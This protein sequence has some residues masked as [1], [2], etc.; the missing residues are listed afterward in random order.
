MVCLFNNYLCSNQTSS[1][2]TSDQP[3]PLP[4]RRLTRVERAKLEALH[5]FGGSGFSDVMG[6]AKRRV[7]RTLEKKLESEGV[8]GE[9]VESEGVTCEG[10]EN[11][12]NTAVVDVK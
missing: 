9:G 8:E 2:T 11:E 1:A 4:A 5:S 7:A 6:G 3:A 12:N 10:K